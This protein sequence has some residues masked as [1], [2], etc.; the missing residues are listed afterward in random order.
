MSFFNFLV[1][2]ALGVTP[3]ELSAVQKATELKKKRKDPI[4][5][6]AASSSSEAESSALG[7]DT[8]PTPNPTSEEGRSNKE[9]KEAESGGVPYRT[10]QTRAEGE[11]EL[12]AY[13]AA[14]GEPPAYSRESR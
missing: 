8:N 3:E 6:S 11:G 2:F 1:S 5:A 12:P 13:S 10:E 4:S 14:S 7:A 9:A